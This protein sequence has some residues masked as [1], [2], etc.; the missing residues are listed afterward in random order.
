V[1]LLLFQVRRNLRLALPLD[2]FTP[3]LF[4]LWFFSPA[5]FRLH[6]ALDPTALLQTSSLP[7]S[8]TMHC[9]QKMH[10]RTSASP[11]YDFSRC[12]SSD[13]PITGRFYFTRVSIVDISLPL[14]NGAHPPLLEVH[15]RRASNSLRKLPHFPIF[16]LILRPP[17]RFTLISLIPP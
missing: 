17:Q 9:F 16:Y 6:N 3:P 13:T 4:P 1:G 12:S 14:K 11:Q 15:W 10:S 8:L 5:I 2:F 7:L